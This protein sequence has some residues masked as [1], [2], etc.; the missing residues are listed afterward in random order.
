MFSAKDI[1]VLTVTGGRVQALSE[2]W[3]TML[4]NMYVHRWGWLILT[5]ADRKKPAHNNFIMNFEWK[6]Y[7]GASRRCCHFAFD[8][9]MEGRN[10]ILGLSFA[11]FRLPRRVWKPW[12]QEVSWLFLPHDSAVHEHDAFW[13]LLQNDQ[14]FRWARDPL[15]LLYFAFVTFEKKNHSTTNK[16]ETL[17]S[18][19]HRRNVIHTGTEAEW[20]VHVYL[21][22][23]WTVIQRRLDGSVDFYKTWEDYKLGFGN[24]QGE[25]WL[26]NDHIYQITNQGKCACD[27][28]PADEFLLSNGQLQDEIKKAH[29]VFSRWLHDQSGDGEL[30]WRTILGGVWTF[31]DQ[32]WKGQLQ[33]SKND[34]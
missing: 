22:A 9:E 16:R 2:G 10:R 17:L 11:F 28:F 6:R 29:V 30:G 15:Q 24:L 21:F 20:M 3:P 33:V 31:P 27:F 19:F 32:W 13:G 7:E 26:G 8:V 5:H 14:W 4:R 1:I 18:R 23:G 12:R 34:P 25:F